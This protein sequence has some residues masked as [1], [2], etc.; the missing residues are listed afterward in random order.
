[1]KFIDRKKLGALLKWYRQEVGKDLIVVLVV[2]KEGLVFD[3]IRGYSEKALDEE[4]IDNINLILKEVLRRIESDFRLGIFGAGTLDTARYRFIF[5]KAGDDQVLITVLNPLT[6]VDYIFP[7]A[8]VT[9]EKLARVFDGRSVSPVIPH[10]NMGS[11]A[12]NIKSQSG[13]FKTIKAHSTEYAYKLIL[14]GDGGVGKTSMVHRFVEGEFQTEYKATIG[15]SIMKK[16]CKFEG[17]QSSIRFI[18]WDL[19]G[20]E[21]FLKVRQSYINNAEAGFIVYDVTRR[22]TFDHVRGWRDEI[23]KNANREIKLILVG[24][25]VDLKEEREVSTAEGEA[26]AKDLGLT[27][28]ETSAK[29]GESIEEAFRMLALYLIKGNITSD[30]TY[31]IPSE[32]SQGSIEDKEK[33]SLTSPVSIKPMKDK[34][35][36]TKEEILT[37]FWGGLIKQIKKMR[38]R[39]P[40]LQEGMVFTYLISDDWGGIELNFFHENSKIN[41]ERINTLYK[42]RDSIEET[43]N[44]IAWHYSARWQWDIKEGRKNQRIFY[45]INKIGLRE[46]ERWSH[47]YNMMIDSMRCF[48]TALESHLSAL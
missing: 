2:N 5:M 42:K 26:L 37:K 29:T 30:E 41:L 47:L 31:D 44:N 11:G 38:L 12:N 23:I 27:F 45:K 10:M 34:K 4:L 15:T 43:F 24:N 32:K 21:R 19:A 3:S 20:Q 7:Y 33:K 39:V 18:I 22:E 25:K 46:T 40:D 28:I 16:E 48:I 36:P 6:N 8:Y 1:M 35:V 13:A 14:G 17:L 9:A